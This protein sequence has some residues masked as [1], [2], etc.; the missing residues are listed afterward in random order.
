MKARNPWFLFVGFKAHF[1]AFP[2]ELSNSL[3]NYEEKAALC[4]QAEGVK[5]SENLCLVVFQRKIPYN[6]P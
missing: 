6:K 2:G 3:L 1:V 4:F 5:C